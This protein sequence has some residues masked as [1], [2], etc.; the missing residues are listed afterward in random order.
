MGC[1]QSR[2]TADTNK[3]DSHMEVTKIPSYDDY[4]GEASS[5]LKTAE[6]LRSGIED[7]R[8]NA[9]KQSNVNLLKEPRFSEAVRVLFWAVSAGYSGD[10][11]KSQVDVSANPPFLTM[12]CGNL[13]YETYQLN[14]CLQT[15]LKT[16]VDGPKSIE[17][18][19]FKL[20]AMIVKMEDLSANARQEASNQGLGFGDSAKA[21]LNTAKNVN[22]IRTELPKLKRTKEIIQEGFNE[23]KVL[24]EKLVEFVATAD[25][26]GSEAYKNNVL[27]P[28][29][30]FDKYHPGQKLTPEEIAARKKAEK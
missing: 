18:L 6:S 24:S 11:K 27:R 4:F 5:L 30:I 19:I 14:S 29:D 12:D 26:T 2:N 1:F 25:I 7:S 21:A 3:I 20:E 22:K 8:E 10:I 16:V 17:E 23:T 9:I 28:K 13:L 15:F